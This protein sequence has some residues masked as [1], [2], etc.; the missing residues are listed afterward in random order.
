M[1]E[2]EL[3]QLEWHIVLLLE[4]WS[5]VSLSTDKRSS[6]KPLVLE[7]ITI[8]ILF[9][10]DQLRKKDGIAEKKKKKK[11]KQKKNSRNDPIASAKSMPEKAKETLFHDHLTETLSKAPFWLP[12][13]VPLSEFLINHIFNSERCFWERLQH[14]VSHIFETFEIL[15]PY[16]LKS[17]EDEVNNESNGT[18]LWLS[19]D[20][21]EEN[22]DSTGNP[23]PGR[24][25]IR[26]KKTSSDKKRKPSRQKLEAIARNNKKLR[27][28]SL[29]SKKRNRGSHFHRNFD[30]IS[31]LLERKKTKSAPSN[32]GGKTITSNADGSAPAVIKDKKVR[33]K[34]LIASA[35]HPHSKKANSSIRKKDEHQTK[36]VSH[37]GVKGT[38]RMK[39]EIRFKRRRIEQ[40][41]IDFTK[42]DLNK[43]NLGNKSENSTFYTEINGTNTVSSNRSSNNEFLPMT[44][45]KTA[46]SYTAPVVTETPV[47]TDSRFVVE[48]TPVASGLP[49]FSEKIVGESPTFENNSVATPTTSSASYY[50]SYSPPALPSPTNLSASMTMTEAT[51]VSRKQPAKLFGTVKLLKRTNS[52]ASRRKVKIWEKNEQYGITNNAA[53]KS[54]STADRKKAVT[55]DG[56][57]PT[58]IEKARAFLRSRTI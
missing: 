14:V 33:D 30:D 5:C 55:R 57:G 21:D 7:K 47:P 4:L 8:S 58:A 42:S 31:K 18:L 22:V 46:S 34:K 25:K 40:T 6:S 16:S 49:R 27:L 32:Y 53:A 19:S 44:P 12:T 56:E 24:E 39:T 41:D 37:N 51:M 23:F 13:N 20:P 36:K 52:N 35:Q 38:N 9:Y 45:R 54:L 26:V 43:R 3:R 50:H 11:R 29:T 17:K 1:N 10:R 28:A 15:N 2:Y 48:E